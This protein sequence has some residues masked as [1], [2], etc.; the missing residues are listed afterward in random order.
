MQ[1]SYN[2]HRALVWAAV[3]TS[4]SHLDSAFQSAIA[5]GAVNEEDMDPSKTPGYGDCQFLALCGEFSLS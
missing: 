5:I 1:T 3:M 2:Y 4:L